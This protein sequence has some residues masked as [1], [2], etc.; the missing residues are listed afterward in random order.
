MAYRVVPGPV[1]DEGDQVRVRGVRRV[2]PQ[3]VEEPADVL[4]DLEVGPLVVA[5]DVVGL[6][7]DAL[8]Q[9]QAEGPAWS[10]TN[11]QSRTLSPLP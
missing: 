2:G 10:S 7:R 4:D 5:A 9:D 8:L 1:G 6:A 3:L 11:S